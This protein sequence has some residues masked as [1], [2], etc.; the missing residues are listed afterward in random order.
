MS[1]QSGR[2]L[3][4]KDAFLTAAIDLRL[5]VQFEG[6]GAFGFSGAK[7]AVYTLQRFSGHV[8]SLSSSASLPVPVASKPSW[9]VGLDGRRANTASQ[10]VCD[11]ALL[12]DDQW[13]SSPVLLRKKGQAAHWELS[14]P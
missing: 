13:L 4:G 3:Q 7:I 2:G 11:L 10:P 8:M 1:S 6:R 9:T 5:A 12:Q 14:K